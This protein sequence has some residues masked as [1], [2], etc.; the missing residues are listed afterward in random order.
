M[1][2]EAMEVCRIEIPFITE[3][4]QCMCFYRILE[5]P[6]HE[7]MCVCVCG[8]GGGVDGCFEC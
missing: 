3:I 1:C 2:E 4:G 8:G 6:P 7:G 5:N